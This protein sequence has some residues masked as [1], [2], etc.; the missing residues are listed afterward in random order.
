MKIGESMYK[1]NEITEGKAH[2]RDTEYR[3]DIAIDIYESM[4]S[5]KN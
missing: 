3:L 5:E 1:E 2:N 4:V